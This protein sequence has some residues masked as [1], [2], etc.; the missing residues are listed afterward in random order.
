MT[1]HEL[2]IPIGSGTILASE[3]PPYGCDIDERVAVNHDPING[4]LADTARYLYYIR[5]L[6]E[7]LAQNNDASPVVN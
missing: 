3:R 5:R 7:D 2:A 1:R 6:S 4:E